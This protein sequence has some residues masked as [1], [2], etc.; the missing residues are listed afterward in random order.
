[1]CKL[2]LAGRYNW[3]HDCFSAFNSP[4]TVSMSSASG[5]RAR[6]LYSSL[7]FDLMKETQA[8]YHQLH[9]GYSA[10]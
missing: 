6:P 3:N 10:D 1:M 4:S 9:C 2:T 5:E 7:A 8:T